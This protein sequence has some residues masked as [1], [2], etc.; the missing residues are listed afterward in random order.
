MKYLILSIALITRLIGYSQEHESPLKKDNTIIIGVDTQK[1]AG[2]PND[3][4][5]KHFTGSLVDEG[6]TIAKEDKER[7][8][9][10]TESK[11]M[12]YLKNYNFILRGRIKDGKIYLTAQWSSNLAL[13]MGGVSSQG[14]TFEWHYVKAKNITNGRLYKELIEIVNVYC[15]TCPIG[16][17]KK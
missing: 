7:F 1:K 4:L 6:Y 10:S 3:V 16:Y 17:L 13:S 9:F 11:E 2:L 8:T 5:F 14:S 15:P 12:K